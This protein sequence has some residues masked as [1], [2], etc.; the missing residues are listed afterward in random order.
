MNSRR[1]SASLAIALAACSATANAQSPKAWCGLLPRPANAALPAVTV[2]PDWFKVY[3]AAEGVYAIVEPEQWQEAI[4][5]L[6]VGTR[7][8]LLFD[9]GIGVVPIRPVIAQLTKLPVTVLNSHTHYDHMGGNWEFTRIAAMHRPFTRTSMAGLPH[10]KVAGEVSADAF[11]SRAPAGLDTAR[12]HVRAWRATETIADGHRFDLGGRTLEVLSV[13]GHTPDAIALIDRAHGL[14]WT[15]DS[16]YDG[17]IWLFA[18]ETDLVSYERSIGRLAA[19][20]PSLR[21]LLPAH[22]TASVAPDKLTRTLGAIRAVRSGTVAGKAGEGGELS[23]EVNGIAIR[24]SQK[25]L[26]RAAATKP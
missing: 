15:G 1:I 6:I 16:Y 23:F 22:N 8:A 21:Q 19:L 17:T 10:A 5:Y 3:R 13:P 12:H 11:C 4:S 25:A 14:L 7:S 2:K 24:T 18:E 20:V 9:T 26:A